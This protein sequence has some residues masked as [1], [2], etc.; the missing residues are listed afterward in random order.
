MTFLSLNRTRSRVETRTKVLL[1]EA[2]D[3]FESD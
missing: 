3:L 1:R 2:L